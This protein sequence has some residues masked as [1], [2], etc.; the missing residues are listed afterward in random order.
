MDADDLDDEL[1]GH[2]EGGDPG[3]SEDYVDED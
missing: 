3:G 1:L 2:D